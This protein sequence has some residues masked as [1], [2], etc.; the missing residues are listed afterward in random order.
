MFQVVRDYRKP[1]YEHM[2]NE[3]IAFVD[4]IPSRDVEKNLELF[5]N[6]RNELVDVF[7]PIIGTRSDACYLWYKK[8]L[9][10]MTTEM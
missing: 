3:L 6:K 8:G 5:R 10:S 7:M 2:N 1:D 4:P 9:R